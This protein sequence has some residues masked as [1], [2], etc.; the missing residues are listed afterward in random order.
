[1]SISSSSA[2]GAGGRAVSQMDL[3]ATP[4]LQL[5]SVRRELEADPGGTLRRIADLG[6]ESVELFGFVGRADLFA[7]LL[8][9]SGLRAISGHAHLIDTPDVDAVL[10]DASLLGLTTVIDP[11]IPRERW[12]SRQDI[13]ETARAFAGVADLGAASGLE[14][15]YHNHDWELESTVDGRAALEVFA[16]LLDPRIVLEV[17]T[18]WVEVGGASAPAVLA[19]LGGRV[20]YLH[21]KDGPRSHDT[22]TQLPLGQGAL[23]VP[24]ILA[25]APRAHRVVEFDD[26]DGDIF[27]AVEASRRFLVDGAAS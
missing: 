26:Y 25:A 17:D 2:D 21:M 11:A 20:H 19:R 10:R 24:A 16:D 22:L 8:R 7:G 4:S 15:G 23:D 1:V 18:F 27:A 14:V 5:Y 3:Q 9:D 13:E 12:G 6:F